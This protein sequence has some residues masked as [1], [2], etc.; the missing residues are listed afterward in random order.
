LRKL[1]LKKEKIVEYFNTM[2][3]ENGEKMIKFSEENIITHFVYMPLHFPNYK[4]YPTLHVYIAS[5]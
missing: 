3:V 2:E 4:N 1:K 5:L